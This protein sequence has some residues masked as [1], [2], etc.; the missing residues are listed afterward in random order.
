MER[1]QTANVS[2][3][4]LASL[5]VH[6]WTGGTLSWDRRGIERSCNTI[7]LSAVPR[8][9]AVR[10]THGVIK[11]VV[12]HPTRRVVGV[13]M[14]GMNAGEVIHEAAIALR[15]GATTDDFIDLIH[16]S[17]TMAEALGLVAI[18]FTKAVNRLSCCA[19]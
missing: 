13:S 15:F 6:D 10:D 3:E 18:S 11:M 19:S 1:S 4:K 8:A 17:P 5:A 14:L 16:V 7:P 9:E 2:R 12:E